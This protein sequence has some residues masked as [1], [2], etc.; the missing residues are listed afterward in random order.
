MRRS[1]SVM[2]L[3]TTSRNALSRRH[4]RVVR[5]L[6][7]A[8]RTVLHHRARR[9]ARHHRPERRRQD[10]DD[11][12]HHR[13]DAARTTATFISGKAPT[14][15]PS[16]TKPRSPNSASAANFRS[17]PC[18]TCTLSRTISCWRLRTTAA[19]ARPCSG[20]IIRRSKTAS[21]RFSTSSGSEAPARASPA[22]CR[23]ARSNGWR[24]ACCWRRSQNCFSS[25][26]R[27]PA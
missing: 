12:C 27:S 10:H 13:Q 2:Q 26:S 14:I 1:E 16:S 20:K 3:K 24:S 23:T 22:A 25:T 11:G 17:R 4:Q 21:I 6:Q 9:N 8:Q 7:G 5:R 15:C 18:S 19:S